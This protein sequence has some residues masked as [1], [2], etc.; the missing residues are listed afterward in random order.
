MRL[1]VS[2]FAFLLLASCG[3]PAEPDNG[4]APA[5]IGDSSSGAPIANDAA[6]VTAADPAPVV[7]EGIPEA[8]QGDYDETEES[9]GKPGDMKLAVTAG[10]LKFHESIGTV[11][12]VRVEAP[13]RIEVMA[14][15]QGEGESWQNLRTLELD[16]K[17]LTISG[18]GTEIVRVRCPAAGPD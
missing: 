5:A 16:G 11:R 18:E 12:R 10:E 17:R 9:C 8:F 3:A 13:N 7:A 15:Y 14:D 2:T 4:S 1:A 6:A